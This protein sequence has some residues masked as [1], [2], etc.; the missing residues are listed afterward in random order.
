LQTADSVAQLATAQAT[1]GGAGQSGA[2]GG[3]GDDLWGAIA[4]C[5]N[6][7]A[8]KD[9]LPVALKITFGANGGLSKPPEIVRAGDAA[10]TPQSLRSEALALSALAQCGAYPMAAGRQDVEVQFPRPE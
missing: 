4:P 5:W 7:V 3:T 1:S 2:T 8:G 10:I 6:R 9:T